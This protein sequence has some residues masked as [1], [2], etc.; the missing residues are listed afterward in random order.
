VTIFTT[1]RHVS[2]VEFPPQAAEIYD[3]TTHFSKQPFHG[4]FISKYVASRFHFIG[5]IGAFAI[6]RKSN[7]DRNS[8]QKNF[9]FSLV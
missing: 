6:S 4:I 7:F 3:P 5:L 8:S 1:D 9:S 2:N